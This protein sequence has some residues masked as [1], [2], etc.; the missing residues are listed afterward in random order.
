[1]EYI[2]ILESN[3]NKKVERAGE[4]RVFANFLYFSSPMGIWRKPCPFLP[5]TFYHNI[6]SIENITLFYIQQYYK[7]NREP[8][9]I[10]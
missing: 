3:E 7:N 4:G 1:M 9:I 5:P 8:K 6:P 2:I 10:K